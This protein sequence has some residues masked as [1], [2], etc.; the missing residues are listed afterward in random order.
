MP[1]SELQENSIKDS[2]YQWLK[3]LN[4]ADAPLKQ[5]HDDNV[6]CLNH[7]ALFLYLFLNIGENVF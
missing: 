7:Y 6:N 4:A 3:C 5:G 1:V 2:M